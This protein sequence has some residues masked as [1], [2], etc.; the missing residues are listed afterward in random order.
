VNTPN[1]QNNSSD[2]EN[3]I[4]R[5]QDNTNRPSPDRGFSQ[6]ADQ[7]VRQTPSGQTQRSNNQSETTPESK[8]PTLSPD[9]S[10]NQR[11]SSTD[12][13]ND[14][15]N[16]SPGP[17]FNPGADQP[18]RQ[19]PSGVTQPVDKLHRNNSQDQQQNR[20]SDRNTDVR[21]SAAN[22][23][24]FEGDPLPPTLSPMQSPNQYGAYSAR[25]ADTVVAE[26]LSQNRDFELFNALVRV[27]DQNGELAEILAGYDAY[28]MLAPTNQA[29][30]ALPEGAFQ[31]LVQPENREL[32]MQVLSY[33]IV[34]RELQAAEVQANSVTIPSGATVTVRQVNAV[35]PEIVGSRGVVYGIDRVILPPE[36]QARLN[37]I[38]N[39]R[40]VN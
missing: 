4:D 33:H 25:I 21:S 19:S 5:T 30:L 36:V 31:Q 18:V 1:T 2:T 9:N 3:S 17:G 34:P 6:G 10:D 28:T 8:F 11:P 20:S 26:A 40:S 39:P 16:Q 13:Q 22:R 7:P 38:S 27:A 23:R 35:Q 37:S 24:F 32:L 15:M 12:R 14:T 29:F